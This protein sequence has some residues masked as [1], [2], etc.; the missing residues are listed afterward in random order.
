M[1]M[2]EDKDAVERTLS[3]NP[4]QQL[5]ASLVLILMSIC[6]DLLRCAAASYF[7]ARTTQEIC[8]TGM[9]AFVFLPFDFC[10]P[11]SVLLF[12][13]SSFCGLLLCVNARGCNLLIFVHDFTIVKSSSHDF[14]LLFFH[15][16]PK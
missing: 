7:S 14:P 1:R 8:Y 10:F 5:P 2:R 11:F 4:L 9:Y 12:F 3:L 13:F 16:P 15:S 6:H